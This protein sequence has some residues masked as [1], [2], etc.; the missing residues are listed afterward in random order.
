MGQ[1]I[2]QI[3]IS[4]LWWPAALLAGF[5]GLFA[6]QPLSLP[7]LMHS[8]FMY[9]FASIIAIGMGILSLRLD[10][11]ELSRQFFGLLITANVAVLGAGLIIYNRFQTPPFHLS[12]HFDVW[13]ILIIFVPLAAVNAGLFGSA[14]PEAAKP[15]DSTSDRE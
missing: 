15:F 14:F 11:A 8:A 10:G 6:A 1:W 4:L 13:L 5:L 12:G 2:A 7:A 9:G 3:A